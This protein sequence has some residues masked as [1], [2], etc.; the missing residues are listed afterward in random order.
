MP[1]KSQ[2]S[3]KLS[4][5]IGNVDTMKVTTTM[6]A[7][8]AAGPSKGFRAPEP[9]DVV[10]GLVG[11]HEQ[12]QRDGRPL[13]EACRAAPSTSPPAPGTA[14]TGWSSR[15]R[16]PRGAATSCRR[17]PRRARRPRRR[18]HRGRRRR[19]RG[20]P[21]PSS[22]P[23]SPAATISFGSE[24]IVAATRGP[25]WAAATAAVTPYTSAV[26]KGPMAS[27]TAATT[28]QSIPRRTRGPS[29]SYT[30]A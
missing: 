12:Q 14:R 1:P 9:D 18:A 30:T 21:R 5:E 20:T 17:W 11:R 4:V 23:P 22:P 29:M 16:P 24:P 25:T 3:P 10:A 8:P 28:N 6:A 27:A 13:V 15:R 7:R 26:E 2:A 19:R